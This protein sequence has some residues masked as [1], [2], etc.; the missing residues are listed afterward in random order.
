MDSL[1]KEHFCEKTTFWFIGG[2]S[3]ARPPQYTVT[4]NPA[5]GAMLSKAAANGPLIWTGQGL[6]SRDKDVRLITL[7][8]YNG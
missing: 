7:K 8:R 6:F 2:V 1:A 4:S 3:T 5:E